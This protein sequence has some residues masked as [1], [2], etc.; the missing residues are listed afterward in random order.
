MP[1]EALIGVI[2]VVAAAAAILLIDR[3][4]QGAEH[5]KQILTG[6]ILT[7]GLNEVVLI[8]PLYLGGGSGASGYCDAGSPGRARLFWEF[9]FYATFGVVVTSSVALAGVLL[10]FS[11]LIVPAAIGVMF[12]SSLA[13][14]LAIGW[15][16][17]TLTS[18]AGIAASF[19]FDLP[20]GAAMVC[21][22]GGSLALAGLLYPFFRGE[23][24]RASRMT[25]GVA[26]WGAAAI[27]VVSAL[28]LM[29]APRADQPLLGIAEY[30]FPSL[31]TLYF[32][33]VEAATFDDADE[34]AERYR[35]EAEKLNELERRNRTEEVALDDYNVRRISS[36]LKSYGEMRNGEQFVM[37]EVRAR[38]RE[39]LRWP[40]GATLLMAGLLLA[41]GSFARIRGFA[42][43]IRRHFS[44]RRI[45]GM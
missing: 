21:A 2:Y 1:Q 4:P 5:L 23:R 35:L 36:F 29:L 22:F 38:A 12:A 20:T 34:H 8:V 32:T 27:L 10:V 44:F 39:R 17:G 3:A 13:R 41:P 37:G 30:A 7:S 9:V 14:Q 45:H 43:G 11:F 19:A 16:A 40:L 26:R 28:Q 25:I 6:N 33:R 31:R 15:I 18:A 42:A 24:A